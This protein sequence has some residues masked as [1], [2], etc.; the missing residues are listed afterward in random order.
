MHHTATETRLEQLNISTQCVPSHD[1]IQNIP[2]RVQSGILYEVWVGLFTFGFV[3]CCYCSFLWSTYV[4]QV[5]K[6]E[7]VLIHML[8]FHAYIHLIFSHFSHIFILP[9]Q[10]DIAH[11]VG[12]ETNQHNW[13]SRIRVLDP[14]SDDLCISNFILK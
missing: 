13:V 6:W 2:S 8:I 3:S 9:F 11:S 4:V 1:I 5:K 7:V 14:L 12:M 10:L